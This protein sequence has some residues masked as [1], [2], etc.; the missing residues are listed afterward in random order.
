MAK[1]VFR[2]EFVRPNIKLEL[3]VKYKISTFTYGDYEF[4]A[5]SNA[6]EKELLEAFVQHLSQSSN[7]TEFLNEIEQNRNFLTISKIS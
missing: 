3:I 2:L 4:D 7:N 6:S 1:I 5:P